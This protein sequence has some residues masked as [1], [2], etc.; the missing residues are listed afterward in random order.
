MGQGAQKATPYQF[1]PL[2]SK[3]AEIRP[4]NLMTSN[5]SHFCLTCVKCQ[6]YNSA[7][8]KLLNLN[9]DHSSKKWF[10]WSSPV[11]IEFMTTSFIEVLESPNF[12]HMTTSTI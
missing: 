6:G 4:Q 9:Q 11:K 12:R 3:T 5:V 7:S 8:F 1:P 10:L 2:T